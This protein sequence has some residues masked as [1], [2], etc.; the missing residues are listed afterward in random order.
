MPEKGW[1]E[2]QPPGKGRHLNMERWVG[3]GAGWGARPEHKS[4]AS[5]A[6]AT[7]NLL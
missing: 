5:Q 7:A 4:D 3:G 6:L 2:T 1:Q